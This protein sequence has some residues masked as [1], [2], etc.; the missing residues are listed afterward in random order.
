M[1]SGPNEF[2]IELAPINCQ[3]V[4]DLGYRLTS[5]LNGD[6]Y[7]DLE[8]VSLLTDQWLSTDPNAIPPNYS[9]DVDADDKVNLQDFAILSED[10]LSCNNPQDPNCLQNW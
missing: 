10:W 6:C 3:E 8:D 9:P 7:I 5:D 1:P 4:Q 2:T